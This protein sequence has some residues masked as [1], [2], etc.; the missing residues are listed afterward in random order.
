MQSMN[1]NDLVRTLFLA[2]NLNDALVVALDWPGSD[3]AA[4]EFAESVR[5]FRPAARMPE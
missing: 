2:D 1:F 3:Y 4:R 5:V